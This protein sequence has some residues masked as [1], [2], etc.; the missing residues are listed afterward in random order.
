VPSA[1]GGGTL[2]D[3]LVGFSASTALFIG[4][5]WKWSGSGVA[6]L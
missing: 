3:S 1:A 4:G 2:A 6:P 5:S